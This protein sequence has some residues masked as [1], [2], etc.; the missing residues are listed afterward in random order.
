M[1]FPKH[2]KLQNSRTNLFESPPTFFFVPANFDTLSSNFET[3]K[4]EMPKNRF[5]D[6]RGSRSDLNNHRS[7]QPNARPPAHTHTQTKRETPTP[8]KAT[9]EATTPRVAGFRVP[10]RIPS[11]S[12]VG[13]VAFI[14]IVISR[15]INSHLLR[16]CRSR[17]CSS[18]PPRSSEPP[19]FAVENR[20]SLAKTH[21]GRVLGGTRPKRILLP[22]RSTTVSMFRQVNDPNLIYILS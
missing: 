16:C 20:K 22:T 17:Y 9:H 3:R 18:A 21:D 15:A 5:R 1:T 2:R 4:V 10:C 6:W 7:V 8:T 12:S 19:S 14:V 13:V 11:P